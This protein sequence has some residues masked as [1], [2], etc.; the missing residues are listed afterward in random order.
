MVV[1]FVEQKAGLQV[2]GSYR[3]CRLV[4]FGDKGQVIIEE[5][6]GRFEPGYDLEGDVLLDN[7]K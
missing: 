1:F 4:S 7:S 5:T 2:S 3:G 6:F